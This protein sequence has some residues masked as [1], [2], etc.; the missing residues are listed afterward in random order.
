MLCYRGVIGLVIRS[1][2]A[3]LKIENVDNCP[4]R[5][6]VPSL[7]QS[8]VIKHLRVLWFRIHCGSRRWHSRLGRSITS[9]TSI[10][11]PEA[12]DH[13]TSMFYNSSP[14]EY[15][16]LILQNHWRLGHPSFRY[17]LKYCFGRLKQRLCLALQKS[18]VVATQMWVFGNLTECF[19]LYQHW[20]SVECW[21]GVSRGKRTLRVFCAS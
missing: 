5:L 8:W 4:I 15:S 7:V 12:T 1:L 2:G 16:A 9:E 17:P 19:S 14:I 13:G 10:R 6:I 18:T 11:L 20:W 3:L 21:P